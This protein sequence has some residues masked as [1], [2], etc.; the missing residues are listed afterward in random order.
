MD[1]NFT[2]YDDY[3]I[4]NNVTEIKEFTELL[5]IIKVN[6]I[7]YEIGGE[8]LFLKEASTNNKTIKI[9]GKINS[10][11]IKNIKNKNNKSFLKRLFA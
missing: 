1:A 10:I 5:F 4:I 2:I 7:P 11:Q 8:N 6:D 3:I 9:T